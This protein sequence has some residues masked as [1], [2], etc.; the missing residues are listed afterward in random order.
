MRVAA[1]YPELIFLC[2]YYYSGPIFLHNKCVDAAA[3]FRYIC[4][5]DHDIYTCT[6]AV[7]DPILCAVQ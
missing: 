6:V 4:L 5:C 2:A 7:G 3:A 1:S